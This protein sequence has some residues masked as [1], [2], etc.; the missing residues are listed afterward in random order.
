MGDSTMPTRPQRGTRKLDAEQRLLMVEWIAD[1]L[2][3]D[4]IATRIE[5]YN[6]MHDPAQQF[7]IITISG[8]SY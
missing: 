5:H 1:G 6:R 7:P 4:G 2:T 8:I 3:N